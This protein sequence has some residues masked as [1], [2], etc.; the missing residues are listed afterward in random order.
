MLGCHRPTVTI[1]AG[2]LQEAGLI[3]YTRGL[4]TIV[5]RKR[6]EAAS[7]SCYKLITQEYDRLLNHRSAPPLAK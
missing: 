2:I 7:C 3:E 4:I 1:A 5:D 6:L